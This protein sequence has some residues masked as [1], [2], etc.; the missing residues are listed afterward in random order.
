M[1]HLLSPLVWTDILTSVTEGAASQFLSLYRVLLLDDQ[2]QGE[3][4]DLLRE[5]VMGCDSTTVS[6]VSLGAF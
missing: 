1:G 5:T 3:M 6:A 2:S 4:G